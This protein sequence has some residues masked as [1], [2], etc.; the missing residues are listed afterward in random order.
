MSTTSWVGVQQI[1]RTRLLTFVPT[2]GGTTLKVRLGS[3]VTGSGSDG[4]L[5][6]NQAPDSVLSSGLWAVLRI[7]DAPLAGMDGGLM[8]RATAELM[9][10]GRPRSSQSS[11]ESCGDV[12]YEAWHNYRHGESG[13][14]IIASDITNR[15]MIPYREPA[16]RDL[17]ALRLLLPFRCAPIFLTRYAA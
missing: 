9:I 7:I 10:Y 16:D 11:V 1:I 12:I 13:G 8:I 3:T 5:F 4:K 14:V 2:G 6:L 15:F 17:V